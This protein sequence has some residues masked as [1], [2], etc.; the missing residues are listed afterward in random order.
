MNNGQISSA[1]GLS[2]MPLVTQD[3]A[4]AIA[5]LGDNEQQKGGDFAG[6]LNG[7]QRMA[8]E[9]EFPE[10]EVA[11]KEGADGDNAG[12][13]I[14]VNAD[15]TAVNV[16]G[17]LQVAQQ[18]A[19][20]AEKAEGH[21]A[22]AVTECALIDSTLQQTLPAVNLQ[23]G[24][25]PEVNISTSFL[26][27]TS[28]N[29]TTTIAQPVISATPAASNETEREQSAVEA[30]TKTTGKQ[31]DAQAAT[32]ALPLKTTVTTVDV[33]PPVV[34][35][36]DRL[37]N[38]A[39]TAEQGISPSPAFSTC[40]EQGG[41]TA[42]EPAATAAEKQAVVQAAPVAS[43]PIKV[44]T[45]VEISTM[46]VPSTDRLQNVATSAKETRQQPEKV[47]P[48]AQ[49]IPTNVGATDM[50]R[51]PV[52]SPELEVEIQLSQPRP[53]TAQLVAASASVG[54]RPVVQGQQLMTAEPRS[55]GLRVNGDQGIDRDVSAASNA[56]G[57]SLLN[58]DDFSS[59]EGQ[60]ET[61]L[62][63]QLLVQDMR[64]QSNP[65][66]QK[67]SAPDARQALPEPARQNL[68]EQVTQQVKDRL[69]QHDLKQGSQQITLTL[70]P[71][72]LGELKM[73]LNL[74]G[75]KLSVEI[76]AENRTV[77]DAIMLHTDALKESLARQN[78]TMES[79]DVTTGGK[80]SGSQGQNQ[81]AWK[82]LVKQQQQQQ[83]WSSP[84]GNNLAQ[85][86]LPTSQGAYQ[87][88][89][90]QSMFDIHY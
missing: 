56:S 29:I 43:S 39:T 62:D 31:V 32:P 78:I 11:D 58:P 30:T 83:F 70:S 14:A 77:R 40:R 38:V 57:E 19:P 36:A 64:S 68:P 28:Q 24:R 88:Q 18:I 10:S 61:A 3:A 13:H 75:H 25:M 33:I 66:H 82:E 47:V 35:A 16:L 55:E 81:N 42:A 59:S 72:S 86:D 69:V 50:A 20:K 17:V 23:S 80:G 12:L 34:H 51:T 53:I 49:I 48:A 76:I 6:L 90:G 21:I 87:R 52:V 60:P 41:H 37:Q 8:Q 74:Q 79:F 89:A 2:V 46:V 1:A 63:D 84:R 5:G 71:D 7:I 4:T 45:P 65:G 26:V 54:N 67:I 44:A 73:N 15:L 27:D 85:A 22:D 9:K